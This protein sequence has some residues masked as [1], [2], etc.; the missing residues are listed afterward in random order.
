MTINLILMMGL[1]IAGVFWFK[2][3]DKQKQKRLAKYVIPSI[4]IIIAVLAMLSG[5]FNLMSLLI[6]F[7]PLL[8]TL[9]VKPNT[10]RDFL[11]SFKQ[12]K[13]NKD[14]SEVQ[15]MYLVMRLYHETHEI[16]GQVIKGCYQNT[17]LSQMNFQQLLDL[18][19]ECR[20]DQ[21]S[22]SLLVSYLKRNYAD[23][24]QQQNSYT[25]SNSDMTIDEAY[26]VL[27][28]DKGAKHADIVQAHRKLMQ[29]LHPDRGGSGYLA[30]KVNYA[31]ELLASTLKSKR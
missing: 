12:K 1:V 20:V 28:L 29:K 9:K 14:Y 6:A 30:A 17:M 27:G 18:L 5:R 26:D 16:D 31:K 10:F 7:S 4:I 3:Q 25:D 8:L 22:Y 23:Q 13:N 21:D 15:S 11:K 2:A 19:D 24:W